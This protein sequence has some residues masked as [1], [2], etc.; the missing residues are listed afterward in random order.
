MGDRCWYVV[1]ALKK[2]TGVVTGNKT[3]PKS[4]WTS[5]SHSPEF[6][7]EVLCYT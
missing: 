4:N 6:T 5:S 1:L 7:P 3:A 2:C